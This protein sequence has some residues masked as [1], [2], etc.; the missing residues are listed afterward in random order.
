LIPTAARTASP[1]QVDLT[2]TGS[3]NGISKDRK[4]ETD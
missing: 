2:R 4:L 3:C 1:F